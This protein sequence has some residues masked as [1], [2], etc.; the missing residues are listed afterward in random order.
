MLVFTVSRFTYCSLFLRPFLKTN[1]FELMSSFWVFESYM[2]FY[3]VLTKV[4]VFAVTAHK[5][6]Y[7]KVE[8]IVPNKRF[9]VWETVI[10][11]ATRCVQK[12]TKIAI[13]TSNWTTAFL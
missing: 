9:F 11:S 10:S 8:S 7:L 12:W 5:F 2:L 13:E 6:I 1:N 4:L 3:S